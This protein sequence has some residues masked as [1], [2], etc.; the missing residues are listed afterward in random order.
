MLLGMLKIA[1]SSLY[2]ESYF[3]ALVF[4]SLKRIIICQ[5]REQI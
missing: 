1:F 3:L 5:N 4:N 2:I